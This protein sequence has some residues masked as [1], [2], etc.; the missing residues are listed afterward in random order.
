MKVQA[1][2]GLG[3][4]LI[5]LGTSQA[6][7]QTLQITTPSRDALIL[8]NPLEVKG[9]APHGTAKVTVSVDR[10]TQSVNVVGDKWQ[11]S[12][13]QLQ[14]GANIIEVRDGAN[15]GRV[16]VTLGRNVGPKPRQ[17]VRVI[18][19]AGA[20]KDLSEIA[21]RT[22]DTLSKNPQVKQMQLKAFVTATK[23]RT[24]A[25][26]IAAY[27]GFGIDFDNQ[28]GAPAHTIIMHQSSGSLF[29]QSEYDCG[30]AD[31][32]GQSEIWVGS[33][34]ESMVKRFYNWQPMSRKDDLLTR[35]EDLANVLGR[36]AAHEL[37][38]GLGLVGSRGACSWMNGCDENHACEDFD[39]RYSPLAIRFNH[40]RF[41]MDP[42]HKTTN[43]S[44]LGETFQSERSKTRDPAKLSLFHRSYLDLVQP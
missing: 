14:P 7:A 42:G 43:E 33:F 21:D 39:A 17:N 23:H 4:I 34:R 28:A 10:F 11:T 37:G 30:N 3:V 40:G 12:L 1:C 26:L 38:H 44:R 16:L 2:V 41:I 32:A 22:L 20:E 25:I 24:E 9:T 18:W 29:G 31:P 19:T 15:I 6:P 5:S 35:I 27:Q 13:N 36:T 8:N